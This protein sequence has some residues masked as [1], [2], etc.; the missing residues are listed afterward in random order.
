[1][2][3]RRATSADRT[4]RIALGAPVLVL[5]SCATAS[6]PE[7]P[8]A[9]PPAPT[10]TRR[11]ARRPPA[12]PVAP[13][14]PVAPVAPEAPVEPAPDVDEAPE[15]EDAGEEGI[16]SYYADALR[17]RRTASGERYRPELA[18]CAHRTHPFG[19]RLRVIAKGSGRSAECRVN[20]RGP[21]VKGR[22]LDVSRS[23]AKELGML[24]PGLLDVRVVVVA[25]G[26]G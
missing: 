10:T 16:A 25:P 5:L 22:V 13:M 20:D 6:V 14:E 15:P 2:R 18:T 24:G 11:S 21:W 12:P 1:M 23:V 4:V 26:S 3:S 9:P 7:R 17:G 19:T 8:I